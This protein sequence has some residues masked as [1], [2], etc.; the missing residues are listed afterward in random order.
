MHLFAMRK[1]ACP[2]I[3]PP[4]IHPE[5]TAD[6]R[7]AV[8]MSFGIPKREANQPPEPKDDLDRL[9]DSLDALDM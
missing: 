7:E 1:G 2:L 4:L 8:G 9:M 3:H 5:R 6:G